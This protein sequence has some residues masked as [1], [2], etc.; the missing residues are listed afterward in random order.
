M[1][2]SLE[3]LGLLASQKKSQFIILLNEHFIDR[4]QFLDEL[5]NLNS[6][7]AIDEIC[8]LKGLVCGLLLFSHFSILGMKMYFHLAMEL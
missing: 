2:I 4:P 6:E 3:K 7:E 1:N 8:K 5:T